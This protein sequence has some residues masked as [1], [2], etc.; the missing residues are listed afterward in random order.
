[1]KLYDILSVLDTVFT[2]NTSEFSDYVK[3]T[4]DDNGFLRTCFC[5]KNY[6]LENRNISKN[7]THVV[8]AC[9]FPFDRKNLVC[10]WV[11][12]PFEFEKTMLKM[13]ICFS[14]KESLEDDVEW[15]YEMGYKY[16][17]VIDL[18]RKAIII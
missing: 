17:Y 7:C 10:K 11:I 6:L 15:N 13:Q 12:Y 14:S 8:V 5:K 2:P 1:M 16:C 4:S 18:Q 3:F 9:E